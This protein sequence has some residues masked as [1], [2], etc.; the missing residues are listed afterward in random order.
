MS[1]KNGAWGD[2]G[3]GAIGSAKQRSQEEDM[4]IFLFTILCFKSAGRSARVAAEGLQFLRIS[5]IR[6]AERKEGGS[7]TSP[8][9]GSRRRCPKW[10]SPRLLHVLHFSTQC[11]V[12]FCIFFHIVLPSNPLCQTVC[13]SSIN[14]RWSWEDPLDATWLLWS[15]LKTTYQ[16][17]HLSHSSST[18]ARSFRSDYVLPLFP[19]QLFGFY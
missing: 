11:F 3:L 9:R 16:R 19:S 5:S 14:M 10:N 4:G 18:G 8:G 7:K 15:S 6:V 12:P 2:A 17:C 13:S 1:W